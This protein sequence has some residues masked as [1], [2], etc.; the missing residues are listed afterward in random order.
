M[1]P[2]LVNDAEVHLVANKIED[3]KW[4]A[5]VYVGYRNLSPAGFQAVESKTLAY[6]SALGE[7]PAELPT[8]PQ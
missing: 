2:E 8:E 5:Q 1:M 7:I 6:L 4:N 3:G